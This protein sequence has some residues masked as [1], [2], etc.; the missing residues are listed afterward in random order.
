MAVLRWA[1]EAT[2]QGASLAPLALAALTRRGDGMGVDSWCAL[3]W[4]LDARA[5]AL[6]QQASHLYLASKG[7]TAW[8]LTGSGE[9]ARASAAMLAAEAGYDRLGARPEAAALQT[10]ATKLEHALC[11][12][13]QEP[14]GV[15][16]QWHQRS[17]QLLAALRPQ[18]CCAHTVDTTMW[19]LGDAVALDWHTGCRANSLPKWA[20]DAGPACCTAFAEAGTSGVAPI[21]EEQCCLLMALRWG[22]STQTEVGSSG[23][24]PLPRS[25]AQ[26][27]MNPA[28]HLH[29][30]QQWA[31]NAA[32]GSDAESGGGA[33]ED[34][35]T[36]KQLF[37]YS[38][39]LLVG[40][41]P[42]LQGAHDLRARFY[43]SYGGSN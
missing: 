7:R 23:S 17:G 16:G 31:S 12:M 10:L 26:L 40:H 21:S 15:E 14:G 32:K 29:M 41:P 9:A 8:V 5:A 34:T 11:N 6:V 20:A 37:G 1:V 18:A 38:P 43:L 4:S 28:W 30:T 2:K 42:W 19:P 36:W 13:Q 3:L 27:A 24:R 39:W 35:D 33:A 22:V 25:I